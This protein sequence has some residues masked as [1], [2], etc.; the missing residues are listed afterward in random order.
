MTGPITYADL[1]ERLVAAV[2]EFG[3]V[4]AEHRADN[5]GEVLS[6]LLFW[7]LGQ[8]AL[9][10]HRRADGELGGRVLDFLEQALADGDGTVEN[11]V[12]VSFVESFA[13]DDDAG[14]VATWPAALRERADGCRAAFDAR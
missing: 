12:L 11:V 8:F 14:Y 3:P 1:T 13:A 2:P 5:D 9:D 7:E 6:H 4:L 10:A